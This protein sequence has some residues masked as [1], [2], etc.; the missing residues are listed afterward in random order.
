MTKI[1][2]VEDDKSLREIYSVRLLAEGYT[3]ISSGDGEEALAAAIGER[4]DLI[5]SDVMMPKISGFEM[6]DLLRSNDSTKNIPVIMLTALSSEQQRERGNRL[7]ADRYL[8]KS[9]VGIEDI[10]RTVHEVLG[11]QKKPRNVAEMQNSLNAAREAQQN[12]NRSQANNASALGGQTSQ[13]T[14]ASS[15]S[16]IQG[17]PSITTSSN[18]TNMPSAYQSAFNPPSATEPARVAGQPSP[19]LPDTPMHIPEPRPTAPDPL[20]LQQQRLA[21]LERWRST[22]TTANTTPAS[23]TSQS[24]STQSTATPN[25]QMPATPATTAA[26]ATAPMPAP[27]YTAPTSVATNMSG[28]TSVAQ[29]TN[30]TAT[31]AQPTQPQPIQSSQPIQTAQPNQAARFVQQPNLGDQS[32]LTSNQAQTAP[33]PNRFVNSVGG[34]R[35]VEPLPGS[36]LSN[37]PRI[38][39]DQLLATATPDTTQAMFPGNYSQN[40]H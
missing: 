16:P 6:L 15:P 12:A 8:I 1:L 24:Q 39:V 29:A 31:P 4:P 33:S 40:K 7:G 28:A 20:T 9:Q 2:L 30:F 36:S 17:N 21:Q 5:I 27:G 34:E 32:S 26:P 35:V 13:S 38:N 19:Q 10:V 37:G 22:A 3:L 14:P 23:T 11:D 25:Y 18:F